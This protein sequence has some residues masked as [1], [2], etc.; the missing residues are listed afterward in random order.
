MPQVLTRPG[1]VAEIFMSKTTSN[2]S[3]RYAVAGLGRVSQSGVL[4]AFEQ[5]DN[6]EL[7]ALV[8][9]D[10]AKRSRFA[11]RYGVEVTGGL[12]DLER[13]LTESKADALYIATASAAHRG[14]TER[15]ARAGVHVLCEKPMAPTV[16]DC[17][18]MIASC[19]A[20]R[21][22]LMVAYRLHFDEASLD[23]IAIARGG[24]IGM[25]RLFMSTLTAPGRAGKEASSTREF[26]GGAAH[27]LGIDPIN[28]VRHLFGAEPIGAFSASAR[29][30]R[31]AHDVDTTTSATLVFEDDR[32][33]QFSVSLAA[34]GVSSYRLIG[35]KGDLR[36]EPA[37]SHDAPLRHT[38]TI[39]D[40]SVERRFMQ[41]DQFAALIRSFSRAILD[42]SEIEASGEEGLADVRVVEALMESHRTGRLIELPRRSSA[43]RTAYG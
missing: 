2:Q 17:Q 1:S 35:E 12:E 19:K 9:R 13:V 16:E 29:G 39:G 32:M 22:R 31:H 14:L 11:K 25:L 5:T 34:S 30:Q 18:A 7:C 41:R 40:N 6:S 37:Y 33:A 15:A 24:R 20:A 23:A 28:T 3:V 27:V 38:L 36:V 4:P 8:S 43:G 21:V 10:E 42:G 26:P